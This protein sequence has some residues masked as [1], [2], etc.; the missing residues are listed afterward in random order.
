MNESFSE[1]FLRIEPFSKAKVAKLHFLRTKED[2]GG[3]DVSVDDESF[4]V[5]MNFIDCDDDIGEEIPDNSFLQKFVSLFSFVLEEAVK[6]ALFAVLHDNVDG[7][8]FFVDDVVVVL[9][10]V[11]GFV[12]GEGVDF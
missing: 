3:F 1:V 8:V 11:V 2:T 10:D 6:A 4:F 7:L 5:V 9:D 12:G